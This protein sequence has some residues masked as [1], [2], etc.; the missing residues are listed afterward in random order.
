MSGEKKEHVTEAEETGA[1]DA[2]LLLIVVLILLA[3]IA[4]VGIATSSNH[5]DRLDQVP[6]VMCHNLRPGYYTLFSDNGVD[7]G[8]FKAIS[9]TSCALEYSDGTH[10]QDSTHSSITL[11]TSK[12]DVRVNSGSYMYSTKSIRTVSQEG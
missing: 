10:A 2:F 5:E 9:G 11:H 7:L 1:P 6:N 12:G 3:V 8:Q 4:I